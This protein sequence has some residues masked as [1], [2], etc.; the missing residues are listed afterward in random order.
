VPDAVLT[1]GTNFFKLSLKTIIITLINMY[2]TINNSCMTRN[3]K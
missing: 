1:I 2:M 3:N